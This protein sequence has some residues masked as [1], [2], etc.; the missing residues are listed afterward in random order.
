[1]FRIA[2]GCLES[3]KWRCITDKLIFSPEVAPEGTTTLS[4]ID[5]SMVV[6][7]RLRATPNGR[8]SSVSKAVTLSTS[9]FWFR[10]DITELRDRDFGLVDHR[11]DDGM[12]AE[13]FDDASSWLTSTP[14]AASLPNETKLEVY[15]PKSNLTTA[16]WSIQAGQDG[17]WAVSTPSHRMA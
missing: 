10:I 14:A 3:A 5:D 15:L 11:P 12:M 16:L 1:M 7:V 8:A 13:H 9:T 4:P 2:N 17:I 6:F